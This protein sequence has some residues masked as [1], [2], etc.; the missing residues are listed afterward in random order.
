[1]ATRITSRQRII[2]LISFVSFIGSGMMSLVKV[3]QAVN[4]LPPASAET[5]V[6]PESA[7]K[8]QIRGYEIVLKR[9]PTNQVALEGLVNARLQINDKEGAIEPLEKLVKLYPDRSDYAKQLAE[10]KQSINP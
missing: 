3:N 5:S 1:M 7:L 9:E 2:L 10:V 6:S 4:S 8:E